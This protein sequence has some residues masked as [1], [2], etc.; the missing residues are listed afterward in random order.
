MAWARDRSPAAPSSAEACAQDVLPHLAGR[1]AGQLVEQ[2]DLLGNLL[3]HH[4]ARLHVAAHLGERHPVGPRPEYDAR[5]HALAARRIRYADHGDVGD[6]RVRREV[7][8]DALGGEV[9]ALADDDVLPAA[10]DADVA[11]GVHD[12]EIAG[13]EESV[14]GERRVE[15]GIEI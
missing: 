7:V 13:A 1:V 15:R 8:L 4:A 3:A 2:L 5:A 12:A 10:R 11:L 6:L 14:G 9:L